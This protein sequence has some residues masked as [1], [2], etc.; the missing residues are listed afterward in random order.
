MGLIVLSGLLDPWL[1]LTSGAA[2]GAVI[3]LFFVLD[4]LG[5]A[6]VTFLVL[7]YFVR[8]RQRTLDELGQEQ[9]ALARDFLRNILP[10]EDRRSA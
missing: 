6:F 7:I 9:A 8:Q 10:E 5:V 3:R 2:P 4:L 1:R